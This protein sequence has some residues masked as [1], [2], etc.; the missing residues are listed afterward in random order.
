MIHSS[1][2]MELSTPPLVICSGAAAA[3]ALVFIDALRR[4]DG[5]IAMRSGMILFITSGGAITLGTLRA[6]FRIDAT[7]A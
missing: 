4:G 2:A 6:A 5:D 3:S 7:N 1:D